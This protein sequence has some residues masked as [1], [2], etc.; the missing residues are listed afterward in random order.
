MRPVWRQPISEPDVNRALIKAAN[1][2]HLTAKQIEDLLD[3]FDSLP[4]E[5]FNEL[6]EAGVPFPE[7]YIQCWKDIHVE[8]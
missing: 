7:G 5:L 1:R 8:E 3:W 4:G 2:E 6:L